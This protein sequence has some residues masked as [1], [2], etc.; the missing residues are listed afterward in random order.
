M[1]VS[2]LNSKKD[3]VDEQFLREIMELH[4]TALLKL[5]YSYVKNWSS[6]EDIVQETF[7]TFSQKYDQFEGKSTLKTWL[8]Q[9]GVN[10][11]KDFLRSPK[12]KLYQFT[13]GKI[14]AFSK[15][16][17]AEERVMEKDDSYIIANCLFKLPLKYREVLNLFYYEELSIK[18]IAHVLS[19][20]ESNVKVRLS[21]GREK[22]KHVYIKEV[23]EHGGKVDKI[24]GLIG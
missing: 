6:A 12:N 4:G 5:V 8:F 19:I 9:I 22:F 3:F 1:G 7:I 23:M 13:L 18:E 17:G 20:S 16:K 24:K 2:M 11:S 10:K 15:E 21:R 14:S